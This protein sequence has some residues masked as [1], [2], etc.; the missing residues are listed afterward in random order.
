M[1]HVHSLMLEGELT[2]V[3]LPK[4]IERVL[5]L[6]TGT[7]IWAIDFADM[8]PEARV[9]GVDLSPI[10]PSWCVILTPACFMNLAELARKL[11]YCCI[12]I[13]TGFRRIAPSRSMISRNPG[14]GRNPL[15]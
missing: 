14:C 8:H 15:I 4:K 11:E 1:H 6:G 7:G 9:F 12:L 13:I 2:L 10:Q 5:D 3:K